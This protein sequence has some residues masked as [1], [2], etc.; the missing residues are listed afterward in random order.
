MSITVNI[1]YTGT[2]GN[3]LKFAREMTDR[4]YVEEI[5]KREGNERYEYYL[6]LDDPETVLL[7]DKWA[8]QE[9]IDRHHASDLMGKIAELRD[10]YDLHMTVERFQD[11]DSQPESDNSFIRK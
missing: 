4:G 1:R 9:A 8:D 6:P 11:D 10:K 2:N 3:A 5:R 7:I